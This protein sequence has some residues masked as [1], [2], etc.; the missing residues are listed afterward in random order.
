MTHPLLDEVRAS[1]HSKLMAFSSHQ[2]EQ[3]RTVQFNYLP[4]INKGPQAALGGRADDLIQI[5]K[6]TLEQLSGYSNGDCG[7]SCVKWNN[8]HI[9]RS[10]WFGNFICRKPSSQ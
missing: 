10:S 2:V 8:T 3:H 4:Q 9:P 7:I 6:M 1:D 5:S